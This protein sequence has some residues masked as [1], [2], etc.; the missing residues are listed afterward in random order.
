M[1]PVKGQDINIEI[2]IS[3][4][5]KTLVPAQKPNLVNVNH[6]LVWHK[7]FETGTKCIIINFWS[8]NHDA[9]YKSDLLQYSAPIIFGLLFLE[10]LGKYKF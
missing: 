9:G 2:V 5:Y 3:A 8:D 6:P 4:S 7:M 1:G 10:F